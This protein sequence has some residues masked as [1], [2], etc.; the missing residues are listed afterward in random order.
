MKSW[1]D[2]QQVYQYA[3][4]TS[5]S[6]DTQWMAIH[7]DTRDQ[8]YHN[9]PALFHNTRVCCRQVQYSLLTHTTGLTLFWEGDEFAVMDSPLAFDVASYR[10]SPTGTTRSLILDTC[11]DPW[12]NSSLTTNYPSGLI[13]L[14]IYSIIHLINQSVSRLL[15]SCAQLSC[16][17]TAVNESTFFTPVKRRRSIFNWKL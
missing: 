15:Y 13:F 5:R 7:L 2:L 8:P 10:E 4:P 11:H 16:Q 9:Q 6:V 12:N 3:Y 1:I 17:E 14:S